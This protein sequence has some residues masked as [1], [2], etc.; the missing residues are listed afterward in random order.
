MKE[1]EVRLE[2]IKAKLA[3]LENLN[4]FELIGRANL[5]L[6]AVSTEKNFLEVLENLSLLSNNNGL[7]LES[8]Q[9]AP[10]EIS[11]S[12]LPDKLG[13]LSFKV[14]LV[15]DIK[16]LE[17]FLREAEKTLPIVSFLQ[18]D[19]SFMGSTVEFRLEDY[20]LPLPTK[21]GSL[22]NPLPKLTAEEEK[23]LSSFSGFTSLS[24]Q[25]VPMPSGRAN[26]FSF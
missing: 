12:G 7:I 20:F 9:V 8:F 1:E 3:D 6:R 15:G 14:G 17:A 13:R 26:P 19:I 23:I 11:T 25:P 18:T 21:L 24:G 10:G 5:S 2:K 22:E 4:E 16:G